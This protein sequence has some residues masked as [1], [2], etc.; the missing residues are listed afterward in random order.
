MLHHAEDTWS[1]I[2]VERHTTASH[3]HRDLLAIKLKGKVRH[4]R[5]ERQKDKLRFAN[6]PKFENRE[7]AKLIEKAVETSRTGK[8]L[9]TL[10][11]KRN[12]D[13][14]NIWLL[15]PVSRLSLIHI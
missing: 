3:S 15:H 1:P 13:S 10:D 2:D 8:H 6:C 4:I 12:E 7:L 9:F 11:Q 14:T 5:V